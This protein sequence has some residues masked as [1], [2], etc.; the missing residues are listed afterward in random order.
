MRVG[1]SRLPSA[2]DCPGDGESEVWPGEE[3]ASLAGTGTTKER[4]RSNRL[5]L[6]LNRV[7]PISCVVPITLVGVFEPCLNAVVRFFAR[8]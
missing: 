6:S 2:A 5:S 7:E 1:E 8:L 3:G 4:R